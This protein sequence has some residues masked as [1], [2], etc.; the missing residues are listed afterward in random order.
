[1]PNFE[2]KTDRFAFYGIIAVCFGGPAT[3]AAIMV[4][5]IVVGLLMGVG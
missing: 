5:T 4:K 1:M 3:G 2:T